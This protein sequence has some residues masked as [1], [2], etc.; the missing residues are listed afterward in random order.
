VRGQVEIENSFSNLQ[1]KLAAFS[2]PPYVPPAGHSLADVK[3][4]W[5][6]LSNVEATQYV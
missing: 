6:N 3:T 1:T 4:A 2:R 5:E